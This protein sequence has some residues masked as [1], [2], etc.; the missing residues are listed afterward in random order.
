MVWVRLCEWWFPQTTWSIWC[1]E[2]LWCQAIL[3]NPLTFALLWIVEFWAVCDVGSID[4]CSL[5][6]LDCRST[7]GWY[8]HVHQFFLTIYWGRCIFAQTWYYD[9][10]H[11]I[12]DCLF[13][14]YGNCVLSFFSNLH[15]A[16]SGGVP[17]SGDSAYLWTCW[18]MIVSFVLF[19]CNLSFTGF[20]L[21]PF[22]ACRWTFLVIVFCAFL[23]VNWID[24]NAARRF[25]VPYVQ[26]GS[27]MSRRWDCFFH[28]G[29]ERRLLSG[30][31]MPVGLHDSGC[32]FS[33]QL[34]T[35]F[36]SWCWVPLRG[37]FGFRGWCVFLMVL[38]CGA[39]SVAVLG[40]HA[41]PLDQVWTACGLPEFRHL[42]LPVLTD[43]PDICSLANTSPHDS[44]D[45][46][47]GFPGEGWTVVSQNVGSLHLHDQ[48]LGSGDDV[49][50]LQETRVSE[51]NHR[52]ITQRAHDNN[53]QIHYGHFMAA[54][55]SS[56]GTKIEWGGV[57]IATKD[58]TSIP[59]DP[60]DD[61]SG[62]Y[63]S[64]FDSHRACASWVSTSCNRCILV[65][66]VYCF[67]GAT[68]DPAKQAANNMMLY[69]VLQI[70]AQFGS[71]PVI[72]AVDAQTTPHEYPCL[73]QAFAS[74]D[75][76]D[77]L[78]SLDQVDLIRPPTFSR[79][80]KWKADS[81]TSSIDAILVNRPAFAAMTGCEV[82][83]SLGL[84]HASVRATFEWPSE[85]RK[86]FMW[87]P[88][89]G[90]NITALQ[91]TKSVENVASQLWV[92]KYQHWCEHST[93]PQELLDCANE[94]ALQTL[95]R[96]GATWKHGK[97][98]R[99]PLPEFV[100]DSVHKKAG[101]QDA[102]HRLINTLNK[103]LRRIDDLAFKIASPNMSPPSKQIAAVAWRRVVQCIR[104]FAD[105]DLPSWPS[106]E[107]LA[108][109]WD[110]VHS[111]KKSVQSK[112]RWQ[113]INQWKQRMQH[114]ARSNFKEVFQYLKFRTS[115]PVFQHVTNEQ[116][117]PVYHP[118]DAIA[119]A[120]QQWNTVFGY[121]QGG[122][123]V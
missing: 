103:T 33:K 79:D 105:L 70:V 42:R 5:S 8:I 89:A 28:F 30:T 84:Q 69:Q 92:D 72:I 97:R 101:E 23:C 56:S 78:V 110:L 77:P 81:L 10:G 36:E 41:K 53:L 102:G 57:A 32:K 18:F 104:S 35:A 74:G 22:F 52:Q 2:L 43:C 108:S 13:H 9:H 59:F 60:Q 88:H 45:R 39:E 27:A 6:V 54:R 113:R 31:T 95:L 114:S 121:H 58:G 76:V 24:W 80:R 67:S 75:L 11:G 87:I 1:L 15:G 109:C 122:G 3:W 4:C 86:G 112:V 26:C 91:D 83:H 68:S 118:S 37:L 40:D 55:A 63:Q 106:P 20:Q 48:V 61:V 47:L 96:S 62:E 49:I 90:L 14:L 94:F 120:T 115:P 93:D 82:V 119:L 46:T 73:S 44:F 51:S 17:Q 34:A 99:G 25:R 21:L 29:P 85:S 100:Y 19:T 123:P 66:S 16:I 107:I 50:A 65:F 111:H 71:I 38:F 64:L 116:G 98:L 7:M 12:F 117:N